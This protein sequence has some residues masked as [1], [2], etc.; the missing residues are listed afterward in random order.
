[1]QFSKEQSFEI[2]ARHEQRQYNSR[3]F[4][5]KSKTREL[6]L[7]C[8][9]PI[10]VSFKKLSVN[11]IFCDECKY[12]FMSSRTTVQYRY[13]NFVKKHQTSICDKILNN[14]NPLHNKE[15]S[16]LI[17]IEKTP[18]HKYSVEPVQ[19]IQSTTSDDGQIIMDPFIEILLNDFSV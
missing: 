15:V 4:R 10:Y 7:G 8:M 12:K 17:L 11:S 19:N 14:N 18:L 1:M 9:K 16:R 5:Y 3:I 6:C 2:M 13:M